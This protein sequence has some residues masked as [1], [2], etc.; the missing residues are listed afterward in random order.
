MFVGVYLCGSLTVAGLA[1]VGL[2]AGFPEDERWGAVRRRLRS[3][4]IFS[5]LFP[6]LG[7]VAFLILSAVAGLIRLAQPQSYRLPDDYIGAGPPGW[8]S[9]AIF[10]IGVL[11]PALAALLASRRFGKLE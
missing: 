7:L 11:S 9:L 2:L 6:A 3:F 8:V 1:L 5:A 4:A 10:V